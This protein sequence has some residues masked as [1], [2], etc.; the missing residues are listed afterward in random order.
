MAQSGRRPRSRRARP[1]PR[2]TSPFR[3]RRRPA[4]RAPSCANFTSTVRAW[5]IWTN[6]D[7]AVVPTAVRAIVLVHSQRPLRGHDAELELAVVRT[8]AVECLDAAEEFADVADEDA[9]RLAV[10]SRGAVDADLR[11]ERLRLDV[12]G[13]GP[14]VGDAA[15]RSFRPSSASRIIAASIPAPAMTPNRSPL[16][17]PTSS[18][19]RAPWSPV[20]D[21]LLEIV[22]DAEVL[23]EQ[24]RRARGKDRQRRPAR[25]ARRR[26]ADH[27]VAAPAK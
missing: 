25:R 15:T 6:G 5:V 11:L 4:R 13:T 23:G 20:C 22:R 8:R 2:T 7:F 24:V 10:E 12:P 9:A 21:C 18:A 1:R 26:I 16:I 19:R 14:D 27:P 17:R 3:G